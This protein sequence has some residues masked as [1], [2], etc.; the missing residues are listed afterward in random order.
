MAYVRVQNRLRLINAPSFGQWNVYSSAWFSTPNPTP[1]AAVYGLLERL[2]WGAPASG[3]TAWHAADPFVVTTNA[4][5]MTT[6]EWSG[7]ALVKLADHAYTPT[8]WNL[9]TAGRLVL[10]PQMA[11]AV[12]YKAPLTGSPVGPHGKPS[13][14]RRSRFWVGPLSIRSDYIDANR[15]IDYHL[16][17]TAVDTIATNF[18]T[19]VDLLNAHVASG[20]ASEPWTLVNRSG[21]HEDTTF[22]DTT[23]CYVDDALDVMRSRRA[24]TS[25]QKRLSI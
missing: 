1:D 23:E 18:Q 11:I 20:G 22:H 25:Y 21:K 4:G 8:A 17:P 7:S 16:T 19:I 24:F 10:P 5:L 6:W 13:T 15:G 12:G 2:F 9:G 14:A 3:F